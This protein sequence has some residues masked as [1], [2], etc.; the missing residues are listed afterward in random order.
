M[1]KSKKNNNASIFSIILSPFKFIFGEVFGLISGISSGVFYLLDKFISLII[2]IITYIIYAI[3]KVVSFLWKNFLGF[4]YNELKALVIGFICGF[5]TI[6][7]FILVTI[8][9]YIYNKISRFVFNIYSYLK[10]QYSAAKEK[11]DSGKTFFQTI[12]EY[13]INKYD[14]LS[15]VKEARERYESTLIPLILNPDKDSEK[16]PN[17][18]TYKYVAKN[19]QGKII[20]GYFAALCKMDV[21]SYLNDAGYVVYSI[22]TN[23]SINFFRTESSSIKRKMKNKDL[24][25]WLAQLSTYIKAGIPLADGVKILAKQDKRSKYKAVYESVIYELTMGATFSDALYKQGSIFPPLLINM[26]KSAELTG[27][28]ESTLDEMSAYYQEL[29]DTKKDIISAVSYPC[30]VLVFAIAVVVFMLVYIIPK[31]VGV[32]ESMNAE[33]NPLTITILNISSFLK[34]N[35]SSIIFVLLGS[36]ALFIYL[37]KRVKAFRTLVQ[38][39]SM[40]LPVIGNI[41]IYKEISLFSRTFATLN[42]NNVLLTDSIDILSKITSNEIYKII[43]NRTINNLLKGEKMSET[44]K[45][46]WAVPETAYF[47][48]LTGEGTG[49]L[50]N[51]LDKVGDYY[52]KMERTAVGMMKTFIEPVL[53]LFLAVVVGFIIISILIPMFGIY[54]TVL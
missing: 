15:F 23:K 11:S 13:L 16:T 4:V 36:I 43:M 28:I 6:F 24:I 29:E 1:P 3:K 2:L 22:E 52:Q 7:G 17:K 26:I 51:M 50:A 12:K 45:D 49:E 37:Y 20:T 32:Y 9:T 31:F 21:Y 47:M 53:I 27:S 18:Q 48:I 39:I 5:K 30:I 34:N 25:F 33:L 38:K 46:H 14:N 10:K 41:I 19:P 42:K 8:P 54:Q 40:K 35:Y 44:F